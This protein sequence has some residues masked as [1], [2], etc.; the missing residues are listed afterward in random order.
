MNILVTGAN[1]QLGNE[2]R[3]VSKGSK[4]KYIFTD[5]CDEHPESIEML[6]KLAG[7]DVD[8]TTTKLDITNLDAIRKMVKENDVKAIVNCAAWTNVDGAE[9]PEKLPA[10]L[11]CVRKTLSRLQNVLCRQVL[12]QSGDRQYSAPGR[13]RRRCSQRQ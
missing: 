12:Q 5:V 10:R 3:L 1:G 11:Q 8:I 6:H 4:D 7:E 2:T 9:D 13:R